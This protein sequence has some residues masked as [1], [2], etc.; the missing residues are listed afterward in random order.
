M[1]SHIHSLAH[2]RDEITRWVTRG[3]IT[4]VC[5][6][7]YDRIH[8]LT[9]SSLSIAAYTQPQ[10]A[11]LYSYNEPPDNRYPAASHTNYTSRPPPD[12]QSQR[13][14][15]SI[16]LAPTVSHDR[17]Q[18]TSYAPSST[19]TIS[20]SG[21]VRSPTTPYPMY[22]QYTTSHTTS[23]SYPPIPD[24]RSMAHD[25]GP[26]EMPMPHPSLGRSAM[27]RAERAVS[28]YTREACS[29]APYPQQSAV[30]NEE[31]SQVKKK[32]KRADAAQLEVLNEVYNRTAFPSTEERAAIAKK[33]DMTPRSVQIW[34]QNKR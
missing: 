34:F 10:Q 29:T 31:A 2:L 21:N 9:V 18:H 6:M 5:L 19:T 16:P 20:A 23:Y 27:P 17:Y 13:R 4:P 22:P 33:L 24:P 15:S 8:R 12:V 32:R 25:D 26:L 11:P 14:N 3:Q 30:V 28:A 1:R 7:D